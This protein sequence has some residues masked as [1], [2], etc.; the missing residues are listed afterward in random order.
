MLLF[1][2]LQEVTVEFRR[3]GRR[4]PRLAAAVG[5]V[6]ILLALLGS[7]QAVGWL[8]GFFRAGLPVSGTVTLGG[9]PL[10]QG[11][12]TFHSLEAGGDGPPTSGTAVV[13]GWYQIPAFPGLKPGRYVVRIRS[14]LAEDGNEIT[15]RPAEERIPAEFNDRSSQVIEAGR[16]RRN[17]FHFVVP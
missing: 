2:Y 5:T 12:I 17:T 15:T 1:D 7:W 4:E 9:R 10:D 13:R 6:V 8:T 14:P 11:M 3:L 16:L